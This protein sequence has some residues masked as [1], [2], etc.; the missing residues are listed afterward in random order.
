MEIN[1]K[2]IVGDIVKKHYKT[3]RLFEK[4]RIDFCCGGGISLE[5]AC[6]NSNVEVSD[7]LSQLEVMVEVMI[8]N[9]NL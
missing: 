1:T 2:T 3:A 5:E 6:R 7:L 4:N 8:L 9:R